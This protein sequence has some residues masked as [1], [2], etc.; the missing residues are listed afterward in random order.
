MTS[1][2]AHELAIARGEQGYLDPTS[3]LFVLT[4]A[5][6]RARG[7]CCGNGCRHCPFGHVNVP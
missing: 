7:E 5:T 1:D 3:G 4:E 6:L 2:E